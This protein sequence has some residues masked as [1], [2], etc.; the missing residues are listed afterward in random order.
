MMIRMIFTEPE[1]IIVLINL[2][3][4]HNELR[5]Q[6]TDEFHTT[7]AVQSAELDA[8][9]TENARLLTT[10]DQTLLDHQKQLVELQQELAPKVKQYE[11][12]IQQLITDNEV[13]IELQSIVAVNK[14]P[15][16]WQ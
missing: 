11:A 6:L 9:H 12:D 10:A 7:L 13:K 2:Q 3:N 14:C 8:T 16:L 15:M 4:E 5:R 1:C